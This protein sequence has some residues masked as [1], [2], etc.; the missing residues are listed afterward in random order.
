MPDRAEGVDEARRA[1]SAAADAAIEPDEGSVTG[2]PVEHPPGGPG[3]GTR[4]GVLGVVEVH[5]LELATRHEAQVR[6]LPHNRDVPPG[7]LVLELQQ[8]L[9]SNAAAHADPLRVLSTVP[10]RKVMKDR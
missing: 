8:L 1:G 10:T 7:Q 4:A 9:G 2:P 6:H 5:G 3:R